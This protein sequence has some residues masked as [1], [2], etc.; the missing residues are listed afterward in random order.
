MLGHANRGRAFEELIKLA[1]RQYFERGL[2]VVHKVPTAWIPL[3]N[4]S[5]KIWGAK[6]EEKAAVDF[7]G[8]Y[9]GC[10]I[11]FDAKHSETG[12]ISWKRVE[13]HQARFLDR[14]YECGGIAFI[15]AEVE[16]RWWAVP[17]LFWREQM[18]KGKGS[19]GAEVA[20]GYW[21]VRQTERA[22]VDYLATVDLWL[23]PGVRAWQR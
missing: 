8:M 14:W 21:E 17:W 16:G 1:N 7:L 4:R 15:L 3:R 22:A 5:G 11:A 20:R 2:A 19:F 12:R 6:V 9:R 18:R 23:P 10:G 13:E